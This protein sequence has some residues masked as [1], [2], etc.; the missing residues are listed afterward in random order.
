MDIET[1]VVLIC[2]ILVINYFVPCIKFVPIDRE[3]FN[4]TTTRKGV[5]IKLY[6]MMYDITRLLS[7][8]N[9]EYWIDGGSMLGAVRHGGIIPWDDDLDIAIMDENI[10]KVITDKFKKDLKKRGYNIVPYALGYKIFYRKGETINRYKWKYPFLDIF[11]YKFDTEDKTLLTID[12]KINWWKK[13]YLDQKKGQLYPLK[14]YK[15]GDF[16]VMGPNNPIPY[17]NRCYG[18]DWDKVKYQQYDHKNEQ[19]LIKVKLPLTREDRNPAKPFNK[20]IKWAE[21]NFEK[22]NFKKDE[23]DDEWDVKEAEEMTF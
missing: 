23:Y 9:V 19:P 4:V 11:V 8:H 15:F 14:K 16:D 7:K 13:C 12:D 2:V 18:K 10:H 20:T 21:E 17:F 3:N 5:V 22:E 1:I 6:Q